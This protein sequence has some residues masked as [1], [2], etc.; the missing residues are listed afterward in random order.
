M[1][2]RMYLCARTRVR[3]SFFAL[4]TMHAGKTKM[5]YVRAGHR[6]VC[7]MIEARVAFST[8]RRETSI[9]LNV[10]NF[11]LYRPMFNK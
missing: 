1:R 5:L 7:V 11:E 9:C 8:L 4:L 10:F 3:L 6:R 2:V